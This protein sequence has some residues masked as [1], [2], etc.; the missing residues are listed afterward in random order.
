MII[1]VC[2]YGQPRDYKYGYTCITNFMKDNNKNKY[3]FFFHCWIDDNIEYETSPW[4]EK[5]KKTLFIE[6]QNIVKNDINQLYNPISYLYE[7]PLDKNKETYLIE[8]EYIQQSIAYKNSIHWKK[9]NIYNTISQIY[10]RNKVKDLFETYITNTKTNYDMVITTRFDG[11]CFP[12]NLDISN[13][14]KNKI[15]ASSFHIP[16]YLIPDNF[17]IIPP[18]IYINWFN[19]YKNIKNII[20]NKELETKMNNINE[21]FDINME[22]LLLSNYLLCGYNLNNIEY[23]F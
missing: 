4:R 21:T 17:L 15:Y 8:M 9:N 23:I 5:D 11:Y 1:A 7:K 6:N 14:Q 10:S 22:E 3:D 12:N 13:I 19:I 18:D 16:K 20:N 2:L